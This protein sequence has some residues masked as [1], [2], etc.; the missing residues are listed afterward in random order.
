MCIRVRKR[1]A[2]CCACFQRQ[3]TSQMLG[4]VCM[5][6][7]CG[8][9]LYFMSRFTPAEAGGRSGFR[10]V[11]RDGGSASAIIASSVS[12]LTFT[13]ILFLFF[14]KLIHRPDCV[15]WLQ[16]GRIT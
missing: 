2:L 8:G 15:S 3:C 1:A 9:Y 14:F 10:R 12:G 16:G 6:A 4:L 11:G 13:C 5:A 7:L